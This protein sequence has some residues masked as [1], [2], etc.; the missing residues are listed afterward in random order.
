MAYAEQNIE[1]KPIF[2]IGDSLLA[3]KE[4][5]SAADKSEQAPPNE[6]PRLL[7][8]ATTKVLKAI[9]KMFDDAPAIDTPIGPEA[10]SSL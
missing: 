3:P 6:R 5:A 10:L 7:S 1:L 8:S 9:A 2:G 4:V